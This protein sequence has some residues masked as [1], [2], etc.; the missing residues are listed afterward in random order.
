MFVSGSGA[1]RNFSGGGGGVYIQKCKFFFYR[2]QYDT[3]YGSERGGSK[4]QNLIKIFWLLCYVRLCHYR[5]IHFI[6]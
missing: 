2:V 5:F 1:N 4:M 3:V 6:K